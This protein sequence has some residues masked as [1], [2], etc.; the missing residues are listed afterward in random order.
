[1]SMTSAE[2]IAYVQALADDPEATDALVSVYLTKAKSAIFARMYPIGSKPESLVDV[3][4]K[5]EVLQCDLAVRYFMRRG[6][7]GESIHNENGIMRH[8]GSVNDEDLLMEVT[9]VIRL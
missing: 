6:G 4:E 1:M 2:K 7:E 9:Q 5:Y 3:P 8:Y